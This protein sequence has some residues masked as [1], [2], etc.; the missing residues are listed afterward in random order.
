VWIR[1]T[2]HLTVG[3]PGVGR[4]TLARRVAA[5][6]SILRLTTD[7]WVAPLLGDGEAEGRRD[8]LEGRMIWVAH[9]VLGSGSSVVL[10]FGCWSP[11]ERYA[12]RAVADCAR[13]GFR[14]HYVELDER[15][16]R[17]RAAHRRG[18]RPGRR[19][20]WTTPTTTDSCASSSRRPGA[21]S[22]TDPLRIRRSGS[23][24]G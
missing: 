15:E 18:R 12:V 24:V 7:E 1:P 22:P 21:N 9:R 10:D 4:T 14:L 16:R 23:A 13:A 3:L 19:S 5:E 11:E 20:P 8:I 2:L 17:I 6:G